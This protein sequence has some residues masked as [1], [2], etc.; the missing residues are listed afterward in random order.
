MTKNFTKCGDAMQKKIKNPDP[1]R[2]VLM[3][4][5]HLTKLKIENQTK[6]LEI[7]NNFTSKVKFGAQLFVNWKENNQDLF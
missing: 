3:R 1:F 4:E 6:I 5:P 2:P 7:S